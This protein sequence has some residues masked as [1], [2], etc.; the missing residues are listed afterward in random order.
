VPVLSATSVFSA[1]GTDLSITGVTPDPLVEGQSAQITGTGFEAVI[2]NVTVTVDG[3]PAQ[4]TAATTTTIDIVVP[5]TQCFPARDVPVT[6][7]TT[8][9]GTTPAVMKPVK[10]GAFVNMAVGE[11]ALIQ[12]PSDFCFQFEQDLAVRTYLLGVQSAATRGNGLT[13]ASVLGVAQGPGPAFSTVA[14]NV[15]FTALQ[16]FVPAGLDERADRWRRH[17]EA[18]AEARVADLER[19]WGFAASG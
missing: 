5:Q 14:P 6:V 3:V 12:D 18:E 10:P 11:M 8:T 7:T 19:P 17:R 2:S 15:D 1:E 4:V 9:G 13:F 16:G